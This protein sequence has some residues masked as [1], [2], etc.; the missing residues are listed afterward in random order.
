MPVQLADPIEAIQEP[1]LP[2]KTWS[3]EEIEVLES[4][5]LFNDQHYELIEGELISKMGKKRPHV[6]GVKRMGEALVSVFGAAYVNQEAPIDIAPEDN[7]RNEPEPD[8]IVLRRRSSEFTANPGP[9]DLALV[10]E[11][12]ESTLRQD[13]TTKARLYARAG[14]GE[15][16]VLDVK[17]RRLLVFRDPGPDGY[18]VQLSFGELESVSPLERPRDLIAVADLVG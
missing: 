7:P 15:Y 4:T 12:S 16:W 13:R 2:R 14:I 9:A 3:R 17:G 1:P 6:E 18:R 11:V 10:V 5:G 8:V